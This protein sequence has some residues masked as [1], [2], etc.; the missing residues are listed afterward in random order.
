MAARI[1]GC[2]LGTAMG[3]TL[4]HG[5][6]CDFENADDPFCNGMGMN[7]T[8]EGGHPAL[9]F[10]VNHTP[11]GGRALY[12]NGNGPIGYDGPGIESLWIISWTN[13]PAETVTF[14]GGPVVTLT[15]GVWQEVSLGGLSGFTMKPLY[16][17]NPTFGT[18]AIDDINFVPAPGAVAAF[19]VGLVASARRRRGC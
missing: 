19:G 18:F 3:V 17:G 13:F 4:A 11:G 14:V 7:W 6:I 16:H 10:S 2:V 12:N 8:S 5:A 9:T 1:I 15:P